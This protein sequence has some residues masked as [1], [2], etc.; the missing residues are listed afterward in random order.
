MALVTLVKL[1]MFDW[2]LYVVLFLSV[3]C[4]VSNIQLAVFRIVLAVY[5]VRF[6]KHLV[7]FPGN[8][9]RQ[10][11]PQLKG[12]KNFDDKNCVQFSKF[13]TISFRSSFIS[14]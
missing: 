13:C 7:Q 2:Q 9:V 12:Q 1:L 8:A 14:T 4:H 10:Y 6:A 3:V 5:S 11:I